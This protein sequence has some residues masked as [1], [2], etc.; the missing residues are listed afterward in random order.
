VAEGGRIETTA[1]TA[2]ALA[3]VASVL[4]AALDYL[5][6]HPGGA[7]ARAI[8]RATGTYDREVFRVLDGAA[9]RGACSRH[10]SGGRAWTWKV[11]E[12]PPDGEPSCW[13]LHRGTAF[14]CSLI[15]GHEFPAHVARAADEVVA[16]WSR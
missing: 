8:A 9:S 4:E 14:A 6:Q 2:T 3:T 12:P 5:R 13:A 7:T 10:R 1:T 11:P 15:I 16:R